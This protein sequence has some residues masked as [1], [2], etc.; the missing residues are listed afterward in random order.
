[1]V[2]VSQFFFMPREV[3]LAGCPLSQY[4]LTSK[5]TMA[6]NTAGEADQGSDCAPKRLMAMPLKMF[7]HVGCLEVES[8]EEQEVTSFLLLL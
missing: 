1:M 8:L 5:E 7:I 4:S 6:M 3:S 2:R